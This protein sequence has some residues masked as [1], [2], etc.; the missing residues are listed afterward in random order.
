MKWRK[1]DVCECNNDGSSEDM[2]KCLY[3]VT[4]IIDSQ[5]N[6]NNIQLT[7]NLLYDIMKC[8]V[9]LNIH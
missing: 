1:K 3:I 2:I 7:Q 8:C 6:I 5:N 4:S 9:L